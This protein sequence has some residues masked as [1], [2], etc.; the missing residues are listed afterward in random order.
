VFVFEAAK[1]VV[2]VAAITDPLDL[3]LRYFIA[4]KIEFL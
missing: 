4:L 3:S 2:D 1:E